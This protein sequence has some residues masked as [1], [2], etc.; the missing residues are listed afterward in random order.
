MA[1]KGKREA[2]Y[3]VRERRES[4]DNVPDSWEGICQQIQAR[5][6]ARKQVTAIIE[7]RKQSVVLRQAVRSTM[8]AEKTK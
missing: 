4:D 2:L 3:R 1:G 7:N 6:K 5:K 8:T